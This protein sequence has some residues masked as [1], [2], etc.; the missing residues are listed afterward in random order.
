MASKDKKAATENAASENNAKT[1]PFQYVNRLD[2]WK[3]ELR[4]PVILLGDPKTDPP[5]QEIAKQKWA[6]GKEKKKDDWPRFPLS[7]VSIAKE[8]IFDMEDGKPVFYIV[9]YGLDV[10]TF[11]IVLQPLLRAEGFET[12][13]DVKEYLVQ[14]TVW[15]VP[16]YPNNDEAA[17]HLINYERD[18]LTYGFKATDS[19]GKETRYRLTKLEGVDIEDFQSV[20]KIKPSQVLLPAE[21]LVIK[22]TLLKELEMRKEAGLILSSLRSA[23]TELSSLLN[24][25]KRNENA[26]Q[27][28]LT[29]NPILFGTEYRQ[30]IPKH[31]LGS[32]YEMDYALER[33]SGLV[34][35]VEIEASTH[36]L[37]TKDGNPS[38][39][40][41]HAEQ[42]ILDW[43]YWVERNSPYARD[44]LPGLQRPIG[45]VIIGRTSSLSQEDQN[46]LNRRNVAF[47]GT[48]QI[49]TYDD[50]LQ[51]AMNLL[52]LLEGKQISR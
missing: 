43:L 10:E 9:T 37:F 40:L 20:V 29:N 11:D 36:I 48:L 32:E 38:K 19:E 33:V 22:E 46:K 5:F 51:R 42:Q 21:F 23:I 3:E 4:V 31:R 27:R 6:K 25:T 26:L 45:Y 47:Q 34:D 44:K 49:L 14:A 16:V 52:A 28:C 13:D 17:T 8:L 15:D 24:A 41:V 18:L 12:A 39:D 35:L 1:S 50:L 7:L 2:K 30:V